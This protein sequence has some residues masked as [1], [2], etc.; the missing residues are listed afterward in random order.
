MQPNQHRQQTFDGVDR[1]TDI[2]L[3]VVEAHDNYDKSN[4]AINLT[5]YRK[6]FVRYIGII[7]SKQHSGTS[8]LSQH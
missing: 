7:T 6:L 8:G 1:P 2:T 3:H 4:K 5:R